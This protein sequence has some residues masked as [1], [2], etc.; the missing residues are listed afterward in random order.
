MDCASQVIGELHATNQVGDDKASHMLRAV[1]DSMCGNQ[2]AAALLLEDLLGPCSE[3]TSA[4]E[5]QMA[6]YVGAQTFVRWG[7]LGP[8][9]A[10]SLQSDLTAACDS[11]PADGGYDDGAA[12]ATAQDVGVAVPMDG[13]V[14]VDGG[15]AG[16][17]LGS[18]GGTLVTTMAG[19]AL[20]GFGGA[21]VLLA[22]V[23]VVLYVRVRLRAARPVHVTI[24]MPAV[25]PLGTQVAAFSPSSTSTGTGS[26]SGGGSDGGSPSS[27]LQQSPRNMAWSDLKSP[28]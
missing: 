2:A 16:G 15:A 28:A 3:Y 11:L 10:A 7:H 23:V 13:A 9:G 24:P 8:S 25:S 20:V 18:G 27:L 12:Y 5:R 26:S 22:V 1:M 21:L 14:E 6:A 19:S 17:G 4:P